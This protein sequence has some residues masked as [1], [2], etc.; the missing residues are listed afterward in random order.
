MIVNKEGSSSDQLFVKHL[1]KDNFEFVIYYGNEQ[2]IKELEAFISF[3]SKPQ[4][5]IKYDKTIITFA[6]K[7]CLDISTKDRVKGG[8]SI[9]IHGGT[10][11]QHIFGKKICEGMKNLYYIPKNDE[12]VIQEKNRYTLYG[13][14]YG[15]EDNLYRVVREIYYRKSLALGRVTIHSAAVCNQ[16]GKCI[17]IPGEKCAGKTTF[18]CNLLASDRYI[19]LDNDRL[20]I[21][22]DDDG[23]LSAHSMSSTVNVG[24]GT[25][26]VI[27]ERFK[28]IRISGCTTLTDKKRYTRREFI[29]Q[30]QCDHQT[31]GK[32]K[33]IV[34]PRIGKDN[35]VKI[36]ECSQ[37]EKIAR[38]TS[39]IENYDSSEHPDWL[40]ISN[41]SEKQYK[42]NVLRIL[43]YIE[44]KIP[45]K[46][47]MFGHERI[48]N[49][50]ISSICDRGE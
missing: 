9:L 41:V 3:D 28:N 15:Q 21:S 20:L 22:L 13:G 37:E 30:M 33:L 35:R 39:L 45:A 12:F 36:N 29:E 23:T 19:F 49:K 17:L 7:S 16:N 40:G 27:P 42:E 4:K 31:S 8:R 11:E 50:D 26:K 18:L 10:P 48:Q 43:R 44:E 5:G 38:L 25:M 34:F 2:I 14:K 6:D 24:Y 46:E 47:M 1:Y 32:V